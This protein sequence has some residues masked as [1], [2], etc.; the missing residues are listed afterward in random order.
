MAATARVL[1]TAAH[2]VRGGLQA[3]QPR[4]PPAAAASRAPRCCGAYRR[5]SV[6]LRASTPARAFTLTC[7]PARAVPVLP[8]GQQLRAP[9]FVAS[10]SASRKLS[11]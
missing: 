9:R 1:L 5:K 7:L 8:R 11:R 4:P 6:A 2:C 3:E 10:L